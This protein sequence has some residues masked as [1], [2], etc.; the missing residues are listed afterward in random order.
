MVSI[1][2]E[3]DDNIHI[4]ELVKVMASFEFKSRPEAARLAYEAHVRMHKERIAEF[5]QGQQAAAGPQGGGAVKSG[6]INPQETAQRQM[7]APL[8]GGNIEQLLGDSMAF[9]DEEMQEI[10]RQRLENRGMALSEGPQVDTSL[11]TDTMGINPMNYGQPEY[12]L[13][14][15]GGLARELKV[16]QMH[17]DVRQ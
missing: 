4:E 11:L 1:G 16:L 8:P 3:D 12:P 9:T 6:G 15:M 2:P 17:Q 10:L 5:M 14:V 7:E 13:E